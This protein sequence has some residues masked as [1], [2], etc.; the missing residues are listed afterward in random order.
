MQNSNM[1]NNKNL[2]LLPTNKPCR[3]HF[4][5]NGLSISPNLQLSKTINSVVEGRNIYITSSDEEIKEGDW[6]ISHR[7]FDYIKKARQ[8]LSCHIEDDSLDGDM[9]D[10]KSESKKIILTDNEELIKDGV[11]AIDN[12]FLQWFVKNPSCEFIET[13]KVKWILNPQ[14]LVYEIVI[15]KEESALIIGKAVCLTCNSSFD[16]TYNINTGDYSEVYCSEDCYKTRKE[17]FVE[18]VKYQA[19]QDKKVYNEE[20]VLDLLIKSE[21]YTSRFNGRT[22]LTSWFDQNKKK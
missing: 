2:W 19:E 16:T 11:Q 7:N 13:K 17:S 8:M 3:L 20:E 10:L 14:Y 21:E 22:N 5:H 12:E 15:P 6:Y 18:G 4:D 9:L 1:I